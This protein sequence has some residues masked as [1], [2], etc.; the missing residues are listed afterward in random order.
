MQP[1]KDGIKNI[2]GFIAANTNGLPFS[3]IAIY[4]DTVVVIKYLV[5]IVT[6]NNRSMCAERKSGWFLVGYQHFV[7][8]HC[9]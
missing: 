8:E 2:V 5:T 4:T 7:F 1:A 6:C 3:K 9:S